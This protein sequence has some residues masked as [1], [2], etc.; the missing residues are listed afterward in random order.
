[1]P[2]PEQPAVKHFSELELVCEQGA[3]PGKVFSLSP[4]RTLIGRQDQA[5]GLMPDID[6]ASQEEGLEQCTVSRLHAE[7]ARSA[8]DYIVVDLGSS[9]GTTVNGQRLNQGERRLLAEGD[10]LAIG[11]VALRIRAR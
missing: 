10:L 2:V 8:R 3:M 1:M 6:L 4:V 9:N 5:A 7:I 11:Q